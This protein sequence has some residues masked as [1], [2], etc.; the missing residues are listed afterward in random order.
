MVLSLFV[1]YNIMIT[2]IVIACLNNSNM[3]HKLKK[4]K[5]KFKR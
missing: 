3:M 2:Q 5:Y 1:L 4:E